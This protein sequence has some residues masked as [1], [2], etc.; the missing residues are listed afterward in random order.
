M[1]KIVWPAETSDSAGVSSRMSMVVLSQELL[2]KT[3]DLG[4]GKAPGQP[5]YFVGKGA[6]GRVGLGQV[7]KTVV[8]LKDS[9]RLCHRVQG[10]QLLL[11]WRGERGGERYI[12]GLS[13]WRGVEP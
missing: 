10:P 13:L 3:D 4:A 9:P 12:A 11:G 7:G 2:D 5:V 6:I 1:I 8:Y